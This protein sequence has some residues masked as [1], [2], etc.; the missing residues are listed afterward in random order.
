MIP[1]FFNVLDKVLFLS[2]F[3]FFMFICMLYILSK[4]LFQAV[5]H[6]AVTYDRDKIFIAKGSWSFTSVFLIWNH[7]RVCEYIVKRLL[8]LLSEGNSKHNIFFRLMMS[9]VY[10][11]TSAAPWGS[12]EIFE[13]FFFLSLCCAFLHVILYSSCKH[14]ARILLYQTS[15]WSLSRP[16]NIFHTNLTNPS[17]I[18]SH[19]L[20]FYHCLKFYFLYSWMVGVLQVGAFENW[21]HALEGQLLLLEWMVFSWRYRLQ[22]L[23][24]RQYLN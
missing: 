8:L 11:L 2:L 16:K 13:Y 18:Y 9:K 17:D 20:N 10:V 1:F 7:F 19:T 14:R 5:V 24:Y 6:L 21:Y 3:Y 4:R 22:R 12:F 23:C 15:N